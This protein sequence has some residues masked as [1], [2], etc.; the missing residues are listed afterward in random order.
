M[1]YL[2]EEV[3]KTWPRLKTE[4]SKGFAQTIPWVRK[5]AKLVRSESLRISKELPPALEQR[6]KAFQ[7]QARILYVRLE[8]GF[9]RRSFKIGSRVTKLQAFLMGVSLTLVVVGGVLAYTITQFV[10]SGGVYVLNPDLVR[11]VVFILVGAGVLGFLAALI[12][13]SP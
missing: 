3:Q 11:T 5:V 10:A 7:A 8:N 6:R 2:E 9:A 13:E 12:L 1:G 4:L